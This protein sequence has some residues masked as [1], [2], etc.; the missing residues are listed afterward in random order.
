MARRQPRQG[1]K[2]GCP[3]P[4]THPLGRPREPLGSR[5]GHAAGRRRPAGAANR[6]GSSHASGGRTRLL[7]RTHCVASGATMEVGMQ[8][9]PACHRRRRRGGGRASGKTKPLPRLGRRHGRR[10]GRRP[11]SQARNIAGRDSK[12]VLD[13]G[14]VRAR[15]IALEVVHVGPDAATPVSSARARSAC[16]SSSWLWSSEADIVERESRHGA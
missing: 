10:P 8:Q 1:G 9:V 16:S 4:L 5:G 6:P 14:G 13:E 12:D 2:P 7:R 15:D 3:D 11:T